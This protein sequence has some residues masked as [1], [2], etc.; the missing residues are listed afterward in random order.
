[1]AHPKAARAATAPAVSDPRHVEQLGG[2]LDVSATTSRLQSQYLTARFGLQPLRGA[3]VASI[4][5]DERGTGMSA[6][7]DLAM[8]A[9]LLGGEVD[10]PPME[11]S[12]L[13]WTRLDRSLRVWLDPKTRGEFWTHSGD[14]P[15]WRV[16]REYVEEQLGPKRSA[17]PGLTRSGSS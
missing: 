16:C 17:R 8:A 4:A 10:G 2:R 13:G 12:G 3:P 11:C 9:T 5:F 7:S 15:D 14:G 1:M 6:L